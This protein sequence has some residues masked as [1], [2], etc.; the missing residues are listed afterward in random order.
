MKKPAMLALF[1]VCF[2]FAGVASATHKNWLLKDGGAAC[3]FAT[4]LS[5]DRVVYSSGALLNT[6]ASN[7]TVICPISLASRWGSNGPGTYTFDANEWAEA[8]LAVVNFQRQSFAPSRTVSCYAGMQAHN[9]SKYY[10][11]TVSNTG[12]IGSGE[13]KLADAS[14]YSNPNS[15]GSFW[16]S[17]ATHTLEA[18][19]GLTAASL[20]YNCVLPTLTAILG[21]KVMLCQLADNCDSLHNPDALPSTFPDPWD[22]TPIW[23]NVQVSGIECSAATTASGVSGITRSES[24]ITNSSSSELDVFCPITPPADDS[25]EHNRFIS[26][27]NVQYSG[28]TALSG[29]VA[30]GTCPDCKLTWVTRDGSTSESASFTKVAGLTRR[31][32]L[33]VYKTLIGPEV[34]VGVMCRLPSNVTLEGITSTVSVSPVDDNGI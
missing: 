5:D 28:G 18:N 24:G 19:E 8:M 10:S 25:A 16:G 7:R 13:I 12:G 33:D 34:Q 9:G 2:L 15:F 4:P 11:T 30:G 31:V 21:Y 3:H 27:T 14:N 17:D 26:F 1:G 20:D 22:L 6:T 29:C 23:N 32:R